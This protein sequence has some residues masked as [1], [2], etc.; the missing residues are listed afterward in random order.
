M[1]QQKGEK[2]TEEEIKN[3]ERRFRLIDM[4]DSGTI[5]WNEF[6]DFETADLLARKNKVIML[7]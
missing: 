3:E 4:D 1:K 6:I 2:M 5:T 7:L